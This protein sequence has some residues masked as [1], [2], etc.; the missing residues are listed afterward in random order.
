MSLLNRKRTILAKIQPTPGQDSVPTGAANAI[1]VRNLDIAPLNS[2]NVSRDLVRAYYGNSDQL[3]ASVSVGCSFEV[4]LAG[5]GSAGTTAPAWGALLRGCAFSETALAAAQT[6]TLVTP[7]TSTTAKLAAGASAVDDTYNGMIITTTG[8]T[9]SGQT[10]VITDYVGSSKVA[11]VDYAW[12][13]TPDATTTYSVEACHVYRPVSTGFEALSIYYNIDG[14]QHNLTDVRGNVSAE[15][16]ADGIPVLRFQMVGLY[17]APADVAVPT[18]TLTAW[19]QPLPVTKLNT[20]P[21]LHGVATVMQSVAIDA[22]NSVVFRSL[23]GMALESVL[24]TDRKSS[25][26]VAIEATTVATKNWWASIKAN[27]LGTLAVRHGTT[28]GNRVVLSS[29]TAQLTNP[30]YQDSDGVAMM[31]SGLVLI[32]TSAGN[33]EL[34]I[35]AA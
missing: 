17:V 7:F 18:T 30:S 29:P 19:Q 11:T 22:G 10:R 28:A 1:L 25:G 6:G 15:V 21:S 35:C 32:P 23:P 4:E 31:Q 5:S 8:G 13:V 26:S 24:I 3:A 14:V 9:G 2:V 12:G 16:A 34:L 27:T 20:V 33:D